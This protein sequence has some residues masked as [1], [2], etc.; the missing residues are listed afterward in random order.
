MRNDQG[1][2]QRKSLISFQIGQPT[3]KE[4]REK[5]HDHQNKGSSP[6]ELILWIV[7][8]DR[9]VKNQNRHRCNWVEDS[10]WPKGREQ[11]GKD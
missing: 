1:N 6:S 5:N 7:W 8:H 10:F 4:I 11:G 2:W 9:E 3:R